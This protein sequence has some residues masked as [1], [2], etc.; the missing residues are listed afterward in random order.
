MTARP[1]RFS[2]VEAFLGRKG[3]RLTRPR[4]CV[5]EKLLGARNH[6]NAD[7]ISD[8]LR[9]EGA[10]VSKATVYRTLALLKGSGL[11][12]QHDFGAGR[13]V[14]EPAMGRPHHDHL[15]CIGCGRIL[16]FVDPEIERRQEVITRR[17]RFQAVYHSHKIFGYCDTCRRKG[18]P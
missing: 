6:L 10:G 14:Y 13:C 2:A 4:R 15:Y 11:F 12:D 8:E 16:E 5:V 3:L 1:N 18:K 17:Y 7:Q 9:R